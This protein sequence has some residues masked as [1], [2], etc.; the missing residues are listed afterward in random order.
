MG[1]T[2]T[3]KGNQNLAER[4]YGIL[5]NLAASG[6]LAVIDIAGERNSLQIQRTWNN[7]TIK[8]L[9]C[10]EWKEFRQALNI[11]LIVG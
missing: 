4:L 1:S 3:A 8:A 2:R 10:L 11:P 7:I 9:R 5:L 6:L